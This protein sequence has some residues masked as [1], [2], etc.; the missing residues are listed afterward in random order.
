[1]SAARSLPG[2]VMI[3]STFQRQDFATCWADWLHERGVVVERFD[4]TDEL[5]SVPPSMQ[6]LLWHTAPRLLAALVSRR[7]LGR[8]ATFEP[9]LVIVVSGTLVSRRAVEVLRRRHDARVFHFHNEDLANRRNT[10]ATLRAAAPAYDH[11]FTTKTFNVEAWRQ[12]GVEHVSFLP[13]GYRPNCHFPVPVTEADRSRFGSPLAFVGTFERSRAVLLESVVDLGLRIWGNDWDGRPLAAAVRRAV[14]GRPVFCEEMSRVFNASSICLAFLRKA[15]RDRHTSR[16]FEIP[17][18]GGFQLSERS[19]EILSFFDEGREI[20]CFADA[21][22][23]RDKARFYLANEPVR[24]R[25]AE[26]GLARLRKSRYSFT[27]RLEDMLDHF[28]GKSAV[29]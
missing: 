16:T 13:H 21:H 14:Q 15:N 20:E 19:D 10:T 5:R 29:S 4:V 1:M 23:L 12:R 27:D 2:R 8:G 18:C 7:L 26:R 22:E 6:R 25:I 24:R 28:T 3:C 11:F 9:R 17:A